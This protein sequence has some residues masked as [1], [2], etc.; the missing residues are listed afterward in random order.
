LLLFLIET[1]FVSLSDTETV[2]G[3]ETNMSKTAD[4]I[5]RIGREGKRT[6][7]AEVAVLVGVTPDLV[8]KV[9]RGERMNP[10]VLT[11]Y[12]TILDERKKA[13]EKA[14]AVAAAA[15]A[16]QQQARKSQRSK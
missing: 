8:R 2:S 10:A 7:A 15:S 4:I 1:T 6:D 9:V 14:A 12:K 16:K 11:T 3:Y 13:Q 5:S